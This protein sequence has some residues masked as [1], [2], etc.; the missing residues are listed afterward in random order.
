MAVHV[1]AS[2]YSQLPPSGAQA[3]TTQQPQ[4]PP[5]TTRATSMPNAWS[6]A[7]LAEDNY[8]KNSVFLNVNSPQ[9]TSSSVAA[10][11]PASTHNTL[12]KR[13]RELFVATKVSPRIT[14]YLNQPFG[15]ENIRQC[16]LQVPG[17]DGLRLVLFP[18]RHSGF[19]AASD[20]EQLASTVPV[21]RVFLDLVSEYHPVDF[22]TLQGY[23][24]DW[25]SETTLNT[26]RV[27]MSTAALMH[28]QGDAAALV[29]WIGGPHVAA[30]RQCPVRFAR[31]K[32]ILQPD[33]YT[34]LMR[35]LRDGIPAYCNATSSSENFATYLQYGNHSTVAEVPD[36]TQKAFLKDHKRGFALA[37]DPRIAPFVLNCHIT[38]IG[39]IDLDKPYKEPRPIFD[40]SFRPNVSNFAINDW[41]SKTTEPELV[42]PTAFVNFLVFVWNLR[43]TYPHEEIYPCDDDVSGAFRHCKYHPNLVAMHSY[44]IAG[45]MAMATGGTF[46]GNTTPGNWEVFAIARQ[47]MGVHLWNSPTLL[48]DAAQ[49]MPDIS[50]ADPPSASTVQSFTLAEAD[51]RHRGVLDQDGNRLSP[52]FNHHVDDNMYADTRANLHRT[53]A[54]SV[55]SLYEVLG[56]PEKCA[57]DPLSHEKLETFYNHQRKVVGYHIDTR[58]MSVGLLD[59]K[60]DQAVELLLSWKTR[61]FFT[62]PEISVLHGTLESISRYTQWARPWF[63]ALQNVIRDELTRRYHVL[64]RYYHKIGRAEKLQAALPPSLQH[65]FDSLVS[66]DKAALLWRS[67]A[68]I[69]MTSQVQLCV[70]ALHEYL[71][72]KTNLWE[73]KIGFII[74]R[75]P[76]MV[77]YGDASLLGGGGHYPRL[78]F[79]FDILWSPR[80]RAAVSLQPSDPEFLHINVLEFIVVVLQYA[81]TIVRLG[82]LPNHVA[83]ESFPNG[84]PALPVLLAMT[85]NTAAKLWMNRC[86]TKSATGQ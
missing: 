67:R 16:F 39:M 19:L 69:T 20:W 21:V 75:D 24:K 72:D 31:L 38:P 63:Y 80:V 47:A 70:A 29:R 3:S 12:S 10:V 66:K 85:D 1:P 62:L 33:T 51:T 30:H 41:T 18:L 53:I 79:W 36:K 82:S 59:Y 50:I 54:A 42:F 68:K 35:I 52:P 86:T 48:D 57:P 44:F 34:T 2:M 32:A 64:Q 6:K 25:L 46:G 8:P 27:R 55:M 61:H 26:E 76:H 56:Y 60:R 37:F 9:A 23:P 84:P 73:T 13:E 14:A 17:K 81:A 74:A 65:R 49:Y 5:G 4:D 28:F 58:K 15:K 22:H 78:H 77:S 7:T 45:V 43:I 40:S 71:A 83:A 11:P